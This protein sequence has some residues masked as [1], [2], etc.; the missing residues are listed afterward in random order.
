MK[1]RIVERH[2]NSTLFQGSVVTTID[3]T[4]VTGNYFEAVL[5]PSWLAVRNGRL[6]LVMR[7]RLIV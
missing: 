3:M 4:V 6:F 2:D 1:D 7:S 5:K